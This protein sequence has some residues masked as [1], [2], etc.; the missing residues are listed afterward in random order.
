[1]HDAF[2][3]NA[4]PPHIDAGEQE[5]PDHVDE[6]PVP[7]GELGAEMLLRAELSKDGAQQAYAE[8]NR[9]DDHVG[10]VKAGRHEKRRAVDVAFEG[11]MRVAVLVGLD[12]GE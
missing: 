6:M 2:R 4:G 1:M 10:A 9:A 12:A 7:G 11:E 8:K 3:V 5:Q